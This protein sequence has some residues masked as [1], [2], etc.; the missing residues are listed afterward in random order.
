MTRYLGIAAIG[1]LLGIGARGAGTTHAQEA[2]PD[3]E[4]QHQQHEKNVQEREQRRARHRE[5]MQEHSQRQQRRDE[6]HDEKLK[7][8]NELSG[9]DASAPQQHQPQPNQKQP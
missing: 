3:V 8:K 4:R 5:Q 9:Q 2:F 6:R 7:R 1:L